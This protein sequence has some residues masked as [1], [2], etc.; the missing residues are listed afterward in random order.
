MKV[1]GKNLIQGVVAAKLEAEKPE[2]RVILKLLA[3]TYGGTVLLGDPKDQTENSVNLV[4][5]P[6]IQITSKLD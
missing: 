5:S 2:E 3:N 1:T 4:I 6:F